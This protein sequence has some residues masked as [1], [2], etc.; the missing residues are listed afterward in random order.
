M[1]AIVLYVGLVLG[2]GVLVVV[3]IETVL[4]GFER[5][6]ERAAIVDRPRSALESVAFGKTALVGTGRP[7]GHVENVPFGG[8]ERALFYDV[9]VDDTN[10]LETAHVHERVGPSFLLE[11]DDEARVRVDASELRLDLSTDR[12]WSTE[13]AS[14]EPIT[15]DLAAFAE[16]EGVPSQGLERDRRFAYEYLAPGD[17]VFVYGR[18]VPDDAR[19]A[20]DEKSVLVTAQEDGSGVISDKSPETL[21][22]ERRRVLLESV[23]LGVLEGVVGLAAFLW[24]TG[25]AQYLLGA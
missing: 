19:A 20:S 5:Y 23:S 14:H 13:I 7:D 25:V 6:E 21:L 3:G 16:T 8:R 22:A 12:Q 1:L 10:K 4:S 11:T 9:T 15:D 24:L 18:A 2:S 17:E